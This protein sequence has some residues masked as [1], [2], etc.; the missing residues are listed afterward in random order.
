VDQ[1]F[2]ALTTESSLKYGEAFNPLQPNLTHMLGLIAAA[3]DAKGL[4]MKF[5]DAM[6]SNPAAGP[7][8][9]EQQDSAATTDKPVFH[10]LRKQ[11]EL[12]YEP[13][14]LALLR[15]ALAD[16]LFQYKFSNVYPH[17]FDDYDFSHS[18]QAL[19]AQFDP[20]LV[21]FNRDVAV[22]LTRLQNKVLK[23]QKDN[24]GRWNVEFASSGIV[25][26]RT[27][28]GV[29]AEADV[30][31][32][33]SFKNTPPPLLQDFMKQ[34]ATAEGS[35]GTTDLLKANLA[36][37]A[38]TALTA[39]LNSGKTSTVSLGRQLNLKI[40]PFSLPGAGAAE[41]QTHFEVK[42]SA[43]PATSDA[44]SGAPTETT[45][46]V[47]SQLLDTTVRVESLKLFQVSSFSAEMSRARQPIPLLPP[48]VD[49]PY[50]GSFVK[51]KRGPSVVYHQTF[52]VV[53]A[54]VVPT[55]AD[56]LNGLRFQMPDK[57]DTVTKISHRD[58]LR[59][60][61]CEATPAAVGCTPVAP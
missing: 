5:V 48:F 55:A 34:L 16:F 54:V 50:I 3:S 23:L 53:S 56:L 39:F 32:E 46:R 4:A 18:S 22:Y 41:L 31:T 14:R 38:A 45:D 42:D 24:E 40:T 51:L 47:S 44:P 11:L 35:G 2:A 15:R 26:V 20:L 49:L 43:V 1:N 37:H 10:C 29:Q 59:K 27:I 25:N 8:Y 9:C 12:S 17:D 52:A 60:I 57:P 7:G 21:A 30:T 33:N 28:S 58:R 13:E 19:D 61:V 36:G 6:D